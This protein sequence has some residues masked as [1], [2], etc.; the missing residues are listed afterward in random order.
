ME[1][2]PTAKPKKGL[3]EWVKNQLHI[4]NSIRN[5][6]NFVIFPA[7][8]FWLVGQFYNDLVLVF[9]AFLVIYFIIMPLIMTNDAIIES[10]NAYLDGKWEI[11]EPEPAKEIEKRPTI[12]RRITPKLLIFGAIPAAFS[13]LIFWIYIWVTRSNVIP[14]DP[15][16]LLFLA[17]II[18]LIPTWIISYL[19]IKHYLVKDLAAFVSSMSQPKRVQPEPALRYF[20]W[21]H[22]LPWVVI[23]I[24]LN[25]IINLKGFA[26]NAQVD[27]IINPG[28]L[29][30]SVWITSFVL[31]AWMFLSAWNQVRADVHLGRVKEGKPLST[32]LAVILILVIP[33]VAGAI[34]YFGAMLLSI[35]TFTVDFS[36]GLILIVAG[37]SGALGRF[38]GIASGKTKE[39]K[40]ISSK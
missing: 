16:V 27:G 38:F 25:L 20:V 39:F 34:V 9:Q 29:T 5:I 18:A 14:L 28:D 24:I 21:E 12:W 17:A 36:T 10:E 19:W 11:K 33:I 7:L 3:N 15:W 31:L 37:S 6:T 13:Y 4:G 22:A 40:K 26:E 35:T 23:L 30:W 32:W 8:V 1:K 2:E